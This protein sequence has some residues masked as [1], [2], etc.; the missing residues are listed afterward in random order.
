MTARTRTRRGLTA[1]ALALAA[2]AVGCGSDP[3]PETITVTAKDYS[4][5]GLPGT[6]AAGSTL[7]LT[8][9]SPRELHELVVVKLPDGE[10]RSAEELLALPEEEQNAVFGSGEPAVVLLAPPGGAPQ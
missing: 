9:S 10:K 4:F 5:E 2:V 6:I 1:A 8:N 7:T 3:E